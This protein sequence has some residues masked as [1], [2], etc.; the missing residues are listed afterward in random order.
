MREM[1]RKSWKWEKYC[2]ERKT[3]NEAIYVSR[4]Y[5]EYR[6]HSYHIFQKMTNMN[7]KIQNTDGSTKIR[8]KTKHF[9]N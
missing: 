6:Q 3:M 7:V 9:E 1:T 8:I 4:I 5:L 2:F